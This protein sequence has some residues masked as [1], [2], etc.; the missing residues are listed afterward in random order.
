MEQQT[1][2]LRSILIS[3]SIVFFEFFIWLILFNKWF[4]PY[5]PE[6]GYFVLPFPFLVPVVHTF[7]YLIFKKS[8]H[9]TS[10]LVLKYTFISNLIIWPVTIVITVLHMLEGPFK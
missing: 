5:T 9:R 6:L 4:A 10:R 1:G 2:G 8:Q 3:F 7:L